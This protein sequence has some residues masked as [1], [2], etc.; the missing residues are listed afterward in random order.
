MEGS[1]IDFKPDLP[2]VEPNSLPESRIMLTRQNRLS[3][4]DARRDGVVGSLTVVMAAFPNR[5]DSVFAG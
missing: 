1:L 2:T 3:C 4:L 5:V